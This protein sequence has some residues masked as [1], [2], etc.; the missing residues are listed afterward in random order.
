MHELNVNKV[1]GLNWDNSCSLG[2]EAKKAEQQQM[3]LEFNLLKML[4]E[5]DF[6][7]VMVA[8]LQTARTPAGQGRAAE[9]GLAADQVSSF[10]LG[11]GQVNDLLAADG[12]SS[13]N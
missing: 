2:E 11:Q 7:A 5:Y 10:S 8:P 4:T 13:R 12:E 1:F 9:D 6:R 3:S